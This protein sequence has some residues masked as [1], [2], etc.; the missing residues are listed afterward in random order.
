MRAV[1]GRN[2]GVSNRR[3]TR[4][5]LKE[6]RSTKINFLHPLLQVNIGIYLLVT[7]DEEN[8][9]SCIRGGTVVVDMVWWYPK[10]CE[11]SKYKREEATR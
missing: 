4:N 6:L 5:Y 9:F 10:K 8:L 3:L 2:K 7:K 11:K 1:L